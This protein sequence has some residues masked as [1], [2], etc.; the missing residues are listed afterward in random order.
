MLETISLSD[1]PAELAAKA[2]PILA[3]AT[4]SLIKH[5]VGHLFDPAEERFDVYAV[6]GRRYVHLGF[7]RTS[8]D[9]EFGEH[10]SG[11]SFDQIIESRV[12]ANGGWIKVKEGAEEYETGVPEEI[13][14]AIM[15]NG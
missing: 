15:A 3:Q 1:L 12:D 13:A 10:S 2:E 9:E 11:L 14:H 4:T 8:E 5:G 7:S 6:V